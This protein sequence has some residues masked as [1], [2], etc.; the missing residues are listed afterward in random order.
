MPQHVI[1]RDHQ[2]SWALE[3]SREKSLITSVLGDS[4]LAVYHI[5]STAV[6]GLAAKPIVDMM[7][8]VR[9]LA[10]ADEARARFEAAGYEWMGEFGI[11]GRRYLRKGGD[12]RTHQ[13]HIFQGDD[14][15]SIIRHLAFRDYMRTHTEAREEYGRIKNELALRFPYDI[16][17]YCD[18]KDEFVK[19]M[20]RSVL[21]WYDDTWD[22]LY[23]AARMRQGEWSV[24]P[25]I[26]AGSVA[27]ALYLSP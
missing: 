21:E 7:V 23:L 6:P 16:G 12:E 20:E 8:A 11:E 2:S 4:C 25:F 18:G 3:Y 10:R 14:W 9:S 15:D 19:R 26:D 13:I 22:R 17:S 24:S 5:G 1:V 27:A